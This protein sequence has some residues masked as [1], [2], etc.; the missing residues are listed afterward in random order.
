M[1]RKSLDSLMYGPWCIKGAEKFFDH[2]S[3]LVSLAEHFQSIT[4]TRKIM[5][6]DRCS[7]WSKPVRSREDGL[8]CDTCL[9]WRHRTCGTGIPRTE[10]RAWMKMQRDGAILPP[11]QCPDCARRSLQEEEAAA[12]EQA[13]GHLLSSTVDHCDDASQECSSPNLS[14]I[15][16]TGEN[17]AEDPSFNVDA[18][19][20]AVQAIIERSIQSAPVADTTVELQ[21]LQWEVVAT[22]TKRGKPRLHNSDG[23]TYT[24][25][26]STEKAT[27]WWCSIRQKDNRC[28]ATVT[29]RGTCFVPGPACHNH[30]GDPGSLMATK[31]NVKVKERCTEEVF[32]SAKAVAEE[33]MRAYKSDNP[34]A[35][36]F[37]RPDYVARNANRARQKKRPHHPEALD[38]ELSFDGVPENFIRADIKMTSDQTVD[39]EARH[40]V[41]ATDQQLQL[42]ADAKQWYVDATFKVVRSPFKQLLSIHAFLRS[43]D[44]IKQVP[45]AFAL[46]SRRRESDYIQVFDAVKRM[47][48]CE[49]EVQEVVID[50]ETALWN[51]VRQVLNVHI[52][53]CTFHWAQ[54]IWRKVQ[55]LGLATAYMQQGATHN[56]IRKLLGL[57][58]LPKRH[59]QEAFNCMKSEAADSSQLSALF[60]YFEDNWINGSTW[61]IGNWCSFRRVIRTNNDLEGWHTRRP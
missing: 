47:L 45:L 30:H 54:S 22:G 12:D 4:V 55:S 20:E 10:Y 52:H 31:I 11:W 38:F 28:P 13:A 7:G 21:P 33:E 32:V 24:V 58:Y 8:L 61:S 40:L 26:K 56:L 2:H 14:T 5:E 25:R 6:N 57:A 51:S 48:P 50:F 49:P 19:I 36:S 39:M 37:P 44:C 15:G 53:G 41:M 46:M 18:S 27:Y 29:Q 43:G 16:P 1:P 34:S 9:T 23:Y 35:H 59:I 60:K 3:D 17:A 42:L